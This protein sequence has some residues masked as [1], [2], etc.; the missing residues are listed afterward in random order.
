MKNTT[1]RVMDTLL[2]RETDTLP[3]SACWRPH[4][5][6][7]YKTT[8]LGM[9]R[10]LTRRISTIFS[11]RGEGRQASFMLLSTGRTIWMGAGRHRVKALEREEEA[12]WA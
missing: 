2:C 10:T 11:G 5:I 8:I 1:C 9:R 7:L 12:C 6:T 3:C 4:V